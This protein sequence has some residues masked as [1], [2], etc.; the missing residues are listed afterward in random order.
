M[1]LAATYAGMAFTRANVGYVHAIAHQFGAKYHTPHGLANAIMLPHVLSFSK[2]AVIE[3]LAD[4]ALHAKLGEAGE[5]DAVLAQAFIDGVV[6]LNRDIGIPTHLA[7]LREADI[8]ALAKAACHEAQTGY[9]VP[10]YM[11][12]AQCEATLR[13]V[14]VTQDETPQRATKATTKATKANKGNGAAKAGAKPRAAK[15]SSRKPT[16]TKATKA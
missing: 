1:S 11:T 5:D 7:A 10:R 12:Q 6:Q 13:E 15:A 4:L 14:L 3:R 8:P 9:P 16:A 2:S